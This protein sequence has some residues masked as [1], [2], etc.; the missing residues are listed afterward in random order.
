MGIS[1]RCAIDIRSCAG[2]FSLH[3]DS[4]GQE[5]HLFPGIT[6]NKI[7]LLKSCP[8]ESKRVDSSR[9]DSS[10]SLVLTLLGALPCARRSWKRHLTG[11]MFLPKITVLDNSAAVSVKPK[12]HIPKSFCIA[13][14]R[15]QGHRHCIFLNR[16]RE[17][18]VLFRVIFGPSAPEL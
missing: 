5:N 16:T 15:P 10:W 3:F 12:V 2:L 17:P 14:A 6:D 18:A 9:L 8:I 4:I 11:D 1:V 7:M 13:D